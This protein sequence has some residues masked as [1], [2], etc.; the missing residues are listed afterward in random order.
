MADLAVLC[1]WC[2]EFCVD[3]ETGAFPEVLFDGSGNRFLLFVGVV[4][5]YKA[6][7][8]AVT[9]PDGYGLADAGVGKVVG[10]SSYLKVSG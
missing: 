1:G 2:A 10:H 6:F 9:V 5:T 3:V 7:M 4:A 8:I